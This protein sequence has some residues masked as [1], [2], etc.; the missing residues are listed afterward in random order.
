MTRDL[1]VV[2]GHA[3]GP[4]ELGMTRPQIWAKDRGQV[5][6]FYKTPDS[7]DRTDDFTLLGVHVH[8]EDG[9]CSFIE[10]WSELDH[11]ATSIVFAGMEV[12]RKTM[13][14]IG[15]FI[16]TVSGNF[17]RNDY[18]Y[19]DVTLGVGFYC[20]NFDSDE[21][22]VDGVYVMPK[23]PNH[24]TELTTESVTSRADAR[25]APVPSAAHL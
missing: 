15:D 25:L 18:G 20:H 7:E 8:Y 12:N 19:E 6:C 1:L 2:P 5:C 11:V 17:V 24:A 9:R 13:K 4:F 21:A 23:V 16:R 22:C 3:I 10:A 14:E